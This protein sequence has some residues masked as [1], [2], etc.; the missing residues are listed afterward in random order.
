MVSRSD[1]AKFLIVLGTGFVLVAAVG[2]V[3]SAGS[4]QFPNLADLIGL[5]PD[6]EQ[7]TAKYKVSTSI[8]VTATTFGGL[9]V[10]NFQYDTKRCY[11]C[12]LSFTGTDSLAFFGT[13]DVELKYTVTGV[14]DGRKY[15]ESTRFIGELSGGQE[16]VIEHEYTLTPGEYRV[17]YVFTGKSSSLGLDV[18]DETVKTIRVP[19]TVKESGGGQ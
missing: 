2:G 18:R 11:L 5:N 9:E 17:E 4:V 7:E 1:L 12:S 14:D 13:D 15:L 16:E 3:P 8:D 6:S 19:E 10:E